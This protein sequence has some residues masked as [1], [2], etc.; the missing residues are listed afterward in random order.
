MAV[1]TA[2]DPET[3][4]TDLKWSLSGTDASDFY[5]GNQS[6]GTPGRLTFKEKPDYE[7]PAASNNLYRVTV[8]VSDGKLKA[9]QTMTVMVDRHGG[10]WRS[11]RC[12]RLHPG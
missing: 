2:T 6:G 8:E 5:I 12:R 11:R 4:T 7:K 10:G 1:Y 3:D 9:T